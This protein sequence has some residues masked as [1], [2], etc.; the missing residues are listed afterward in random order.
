MLHTVRKLLDDFGWLFVLLTC[1]S[2]QPFGLFDAVDNVDS[3]AAI[4]S[5]RLQDPNVLA[6]VVTHRYHKR[7]VTFEP[8]L[9]C[10]LWTDNRRRFLRVLAFRY[11]VF[12][13]LQQFKRLLPRFEFG[14]QN[15]GVDLACRQN[16]HLYAVRERQ[17]VFENWLLLIVVKLGYVFEKFVLGRDFCVVFEVINH[18]VEKTLADP[19]K[20]D[21]A[22]GRRPP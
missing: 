6:C 14:I 5:G 9:L 21:A 4:Q 7:L 22:R 3:F 20:V 2:D 10:G 1:R 11:L 18:L 12:R 17:Y 19:V 16:W 15:F 13:G 8:K